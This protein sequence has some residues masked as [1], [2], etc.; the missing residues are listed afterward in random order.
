MKYPFKKSNSIL[1]FCLSILSFQSKAQNLFNS[2][3]YSHHTYL[4]K[5]S[6]TEAKEIYKRE[7]RKA[8]STY[9]HTLITS[10]PT[11]SVFKDTLSTGHYIR[12]YVRQNK[13]Q[14]E[15]TS[16]PNF[17]VYILNNNTDLCIQVSD[18]NGA[19]IEDAKVQIKNKI[20]QF[21]RAS[22]SYL[23]PKSNKRGLLAVS[24]QGFTDYYQLYRD[25]NNSGIKR[26]LRKTLYGSPLKHVWKPVQFIVLLPVDGIK[27]LTN[28]G[29]SSSFY[30]IR[31]F[32]ER[33]INRIDCLFRKE[34]CQQDKT[35]KYKGYL[36]FNK[37]KYLPNDTVK[38]KAFITNA[39]AKPL[40]QELKL[41]LVNYGKNIELA[42]LKPYTK[43]AYHSQ[44]VLHDSLKLELDRRYGVVITDQKENYLMKN[45]F[46]YEDYELN[47]L[48]LKVKPVRKEHYH[49][50]PL[51][52]NIEAV[53]E[54]DLRILDGQLKVIVRPL[55]VNQYFETSCFL[56][57]TLLLLH[58]QVK[59]KQDTKIVIP[60]T[61]FP[62]INLKYQVDVELSSADQQIVSQKEVFN[63]YYKK[64]WVD[65]QLLKDSIRFEFFENGIKTESELRLTGY[66]SFNHPVEHYQVKLPHQIKLNPH[67]AEYQ[68]ESETLKERLN[69]QNADDRI[70]CFSERTNDSLFV[71][72]INPYHIAISYS[73][74]EHDK[75]LIEG[76]DQSIKI[77]LPNKTKH[78]YY[79]SLRYVWAGNVQQQYFSI[80]LKDKQLNLTVKQPNLVYP[81]QTTNIE[82]EVTDSYGKP[83]EGVDL[84]AQALTKKFKY[85]PPVLP[86]L[87]KLAKPKYIINNFELNKQPVKNCAPLSLA[88][89]T[90]NAGLDTMEYYQ[91][92]YPTDHMYRF[93]YV[94]EDS[95]TQFAPYVTKEGAF[96]PVHVVYVDHQ[97][98]YFSWTTTKPSYSFKID[99]GFHHIELRTAQKSIAIDSLYFNPKKKLVFSVDENT[100]HPNVTINE[101]PTV[102]KDNEQANLYR[103]ILPYNS[104]YRDDAYFQNNEKIEILKRNEQYKGHRH[105]AGPING[106]ITFNTIND[107]YHTFEHEPYFEYQ[108]KSKLIKMKSVDLY[109]YPTNLLQYKPTMNWADEVITKKKLMVGWNN[110]IQSTRT[111]KL[112]YEILENSS[113]HGKLQFTV[114]RVEKIS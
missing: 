45:I 52:L 7:L 25:H 110:Y 63:Y 15:V 53:N 46:V 72:V 39:K 76:Y 73:V 11:D 98:V 68:V 8:D 71:E 27:A 113:L 33:T 3:Q 89:L 61:L 5:I 77:T 56:P 104:L 59:P 30:K 84:T 48:Q 13:Q 94:T 105:F 40:K 22:Q 96:Q 28:R 79:V 88:T 108:F 29:R 21:D 65:F 19:I 90:T 74:F 1:L 54:N 78:N 111:R 81:N 16:I 35:Y 17:Y 93:E 23:M 64:D 83:V 50:E 24:Y 80:P 69:I 101:M 82:I 102:L 43:G 9:L 14:I 67:L 41:K 10:Y 4:Y 97:P 60:D 38:F 32:V 100:R 103:Y 37:P 87:K 34:N 49:K 107:Y 36:V 106:R 12:T 91:F 66:D 47:E 2:K 58:Q 70:S 114:N 62:K 112:R 51:I 99:S 31:R 55:E 42:N 26:G 92:I 85:E 75:K 57:D 95:I 86:D 44:F 18:L 109:R 6:N 20:I